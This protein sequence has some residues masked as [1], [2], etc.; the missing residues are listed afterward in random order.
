MK[1]GDLLKRGKKRYAIKAR[2][3]RWG[4]C[5]QCDNREKLY[6]FY[7]EKKQAW[8]LCASCSDI[9]ADEDEE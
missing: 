7:D 6:P 1:F 3:S 2:S 9:F 5:E 8:M 4:R